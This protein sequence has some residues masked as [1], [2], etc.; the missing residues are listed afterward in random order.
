MAISVPR[1]CERNKAPE[2]TGE[3]AP[4]AFIVLSDDSEIRCCTRCKEADDE[5]VRYL[6]GDGT[7][8]IPYSQYDFEGFYEALNNSSV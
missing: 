1:G 4:V 5:V 6:I 7:P 3:R 2:C 8:E